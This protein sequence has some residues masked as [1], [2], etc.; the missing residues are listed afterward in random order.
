MHHR[1][2]VAGWK[3]SPIFTSGAEELIW[4]YSGG[5]PRKIN[6][7]CDN[8]LLIGFQLKRKNVNN[9]IVQ[10]AVEELNWKPEDSADDGR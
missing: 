9:D 5:I 4:R 1:L 10:E 2:I 3:G 6:I 8:S 7:L